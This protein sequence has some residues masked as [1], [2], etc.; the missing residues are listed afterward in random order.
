MLT[1]GDPFLQVLLIP[2]ATISW[3]SV[4]LWG[5]T[6]KCANGTNCQAMDIEVYEHGQWTHKLSK[7]TIPTHYNVF[8]LEDWLNLTLLWMGYGEMLEGEN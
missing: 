4:V 7:E 3:I 5:G 2:L 1:K 8:S 6:K